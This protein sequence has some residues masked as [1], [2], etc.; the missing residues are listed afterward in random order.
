MARCGR[1]ADTQLFA[2]WSVNRMDGHRH[3]LQESDGRDAGLSSASARAQQIMLCPEGQRVNQ[4]VGL[5]ARGFEWGVRSLRRGIVEP[6][7]SSVGLVG[8]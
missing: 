5:V 6:P 2:R 3:A 8:D 1:A 4:S 7:G